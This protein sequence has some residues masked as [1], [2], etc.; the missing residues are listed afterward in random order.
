MTFFSS[1]FTKED[2]DNIP[3]LN[4]RYTGDPLKKLSITPEMVLTKLKKLKIN[5]SAGPDGHHPRILKETAEAICT[6]LA[7]I[8]NKSLEEGRLPQKWKDAHVTALHKK[9]SKQKVENYR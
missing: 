8:F 3:L 7:K 1:V 9:G 2:L 4:N 5:K 6:P